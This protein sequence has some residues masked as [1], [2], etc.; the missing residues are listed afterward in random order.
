M[1]ERI[2]TRISPD[3]LDTIGRSFR[4]RHGKGVAE[5]L[6][7]SLDAYLR[8]VANGGESRKGRWP[9]LID[10]MNGS[11]G[12][13]GPNL[14][15]IDFSGTSF[16][17]LERFFLHWGDTTA[18]THGARYHVGEVTGGHGNGGKFYMREMWKQGSRFLTWKNGYISSLVVDKEK[19]GS[20]GYWERKN[21]RLTDWRQALCA[22]FPQEEGFMTPDYLLAYLDSTEIELT[23]ELDQGNR[24]LSVVVGRKAKQVLSSNDLVVG[25]RWRTQRLVDAIRDTSQSRRP[26]RELHV[27]VFVDGA[28]QLRE[29]SARR[30]TEDLEWPEKTY[31]L[32]G[33]L[34]ESSR[35]SIGQLAVWKA[36]EQLVG[37]LKDH[38]GVMVLDAKSNPVAWYPISELAIPPAP[39]VRFLFGEVR[40]EFPGLEGIIQNDRERLI[41]N[42]QS[43]RILTHIAEKFTERLNEIE[44]A[45]RERE[46]SA[47]L[48]SA[49]LLNDSLNKHAQSFLRKLETEIFVDFI[50]DSEEGGGDGPY[51]LGLSGTG[52]ESG[53]KRNSRSSG[54]EGDGG[55]SSVE[56]GSQKHRRPRYPQIL[57]SDLD[58]DPASSAGDTKHLSRMHPPLYQ[59][60]EDRQFNSWWINASH[61]FAETALRHGGPEGKLFRSHQ[62]FMFR[63]VVQREA[64]RMLQRREAEMAIDRLET[65][66]D[67]IS[68]KF[69]GELPIDVVRLFVDTE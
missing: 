23:K 36:K 9:V 48:E 20:T 17:Q 31:A 8:A 56:G 24:G 42:D 66:L 3:L 22:A 41:R 61:P 10:I 18:A 21:E 27:T 46:R 6:K 40:L 26:I 49:S 34:I 25:K 50:G 39:S 54:G 69:L 47:R 38:N 58:A 65:E 44:Q 37:T 51:D 30:V 68:N 5:W 59:D 19:S 28:M 11:K 2:K 16:E 4:F 14:A 7:N 52:D 35:E 64:M 33:L 1:R 60:D 15:V 62:L 12:K 45:E 57:V 67:E 43:R 32:P 29:L 55:P 53:S 63:D 13:S